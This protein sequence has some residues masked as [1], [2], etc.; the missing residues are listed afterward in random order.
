MPIISSPGIG[1]GLD[2]DKIISG[3][4]AVERQPLTSLKNKQEQYSVKISNYGQLVGALSSFQASLASLSSF[5]TIGNYVASSSNSDVFTVA[6]SSVADAGNYS[7]EVVRLAEQHK[8]GSKEIDSAATF[9]GGVGDSFAVQVGSNP[10][11]S[12]SIDLSSALTLSQIRD[13]INDGVDNPGITATIINGSGTN[14]KLMITSNEVGESEAL[15]VSVSGAILSTTFDFQ[16]INNIGGDLSLLDS[17][18]I[19]DGY[20]INRST[21][22]IDDVINGV[23]INLVSADPGNNHTL[24]VARNNA[25]IESAVQSFVD[26]F[27]NLRSTIKTLRNGALAS[28]NILLSIERQ[29]L[30]VINNSASGGSFRYLTEVGLTMQKDGT[31][32]L[33]TGVLSES[34]ASD[35]DG[36]AQLFSAENQGYANRLNTMIGGWINNGGIM[37]SRTESLNQLIKGLTDKQTNI[38]RNLLLVE[39]RYRAQFSQLDE[40]VGLLQSTSQFLTQQLASLPEPNVI[41]K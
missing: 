40:L 3:L 20:T 1:S 13:A 22:S 12:I 23:T 19:V 32:A 31:M 5:S 37:D 8:M 16:T 7:M 18:I 36:V 29:V 30:G 11:D 17:E 25:Q 4:M 26:G 41:R 9:G 21:N 34:I 24:V 27:N 28:D 39:A 2:V 14:Q 38:E 10:S 6:S 35:F 33:D 15:T